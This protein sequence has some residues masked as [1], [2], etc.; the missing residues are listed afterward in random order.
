MNTAR[1]LLLK[2]ISS[3]VRG[4]IVSKSVRS[5]STTITQFTPEFNKHNAEKSSFA[6]KF[7]L[8]SILQRFKGSISG[9]SVMHESINTLQMKKRPI[10]K[11]RQEAEV[12]YFG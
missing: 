3:N 12:G 6:K 10:R 4:T 8:N 7:A 5:I 1:A 2:C 9:G 11:R